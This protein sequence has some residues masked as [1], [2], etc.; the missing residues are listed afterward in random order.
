MV[1]KFKE[2]EMANHGFMSITGKK[3]GLISQAVLV[4]FLSA[5]N[6]RSATLMKS[7]C[8]LIR[9]TWLQE[10]MEQ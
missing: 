7:W 1:G 9:M 6:V 3:Q 4:K 10:V 5:I 8:W 2:Y